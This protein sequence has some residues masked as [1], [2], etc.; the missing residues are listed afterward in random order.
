MA[1]TYEANENF[2]L[3]QEEIAKSPVYAGMPDLRNEDGSIQW[4]APSNRGSGIHKDTHDKRLQWWKDK[5]ISMGISLYK[6][7]W[8][9][10]T[11]KLIHP[12]KQKP[13]KYCGRVMDIRYCY[14]SKRLIDRIQKL[15]YVHDNLKLTETTSIFEVI[16]A[17][18]DLYKTQ[19]YSDLPRL[20]VCK[21]YNNIPSLP[22]SID[23]WMDW[24]EREYIPSEPSLLGPGAMSNAPDRLDGFHSFNRCCR[25]KADRGRSK[26]NLASYS[27]DRR[28]FEYWSDGN[29]ITANKLMGAINSM[30][31]LMQE[32]CLHHGD[33]G[34]HPRPCSADHVGPIS[35]GFAH[36]AAFQLLCRPCNSAKNNRLSF[37]DVKQLIES[38]DEGNQVVSWYAQP[39]WDKLKHKVESDSDA[40]K[41]SRIM[42][43][44]RYSALC[45]LND[46]MEEKLYLLLYSLLN[47]HYAEYTYIIQETKIDGHIVTASFSRVPSELKYVCIQKARKA[48]IAFSSLRDYSKKE[49]RNGL[50]ID[51][52]NYKDKFEE[53]RKYM[54]SVEKNYHKFCDLLIKAVDSG[55][56]EK[57]R[58]VI[59][60]MPNTRDISEIKECKR[61]LIDIMENIASTLVSMWTD[62]RFSRE[63]S[64]Y[65]H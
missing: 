42:R 50:Y 54:S 46:L 30:P 10:K 37:S 16:P 1:K 35:L 43:D 32:S 62:G 34:N 39:I 7:K 19:V 52:P 18:I 3:Y 12:T 36:R 5:A 28:A 25:G 17:M 64:E 24:L 59:E 58:I 65:S 21:S 9:S 57:L 8:I 22:N 55:S 40:S 44:N 41:L 11:A 2:I 51:I 6:N 27:T 48:R 26:S 13:C 38:E 61:V 14:L 60:S 56:E 53:I 49:K 33:G 29:W 47:L 31:N 23:A 20:F 45:I 4:E 63:I 15:H